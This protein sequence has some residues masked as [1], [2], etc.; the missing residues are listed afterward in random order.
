MR[1]GANAPAMLKNVSSSIIHH[2]DKEGH[3]GEIRYDE[4][5]IQMG[6]GRKLT[7][8]ECLEEEDE[9]VKEFGRIANKISRLIRALDPIYEEIEEDLVGFT[10]R[11]NERVRSIDQLSFNRRL[12]LL[13]TYYTLNSKHDRILRK[14]T[15]HLIAGSEGDH[16]PNNLSLVRRAIDYTCR[17]MRRQS[18]KT[19]HPAALHAIEA[20]RGAAK[21]GLRIVTIIATLLHDVLEERLDEWT[22]AM[23]DRELTDQAYGEYCGRRMKEVPLALRHKIIQKHIDAYN[24]RASGIFFHIGLTL[25]DH[26]R[27]FPVP[28]RHYESLHSIAEMVSALSRRKDQSYYSYLQL[29]LYPK[30]KTELDT[31]EY[32]R[33]RE[34]LIPEHPDADRLLDPYLN[35]VHTFYQ[36]QLGQFSAIEEVRRNAFREILAKILDRMN[37]TRDMDRRHGF[38]V[39][40]RLYGTGFKNIFFLQ[41][42][43][44]K[45]RRPSF[46]TEERRLIELKFINKPKV[47]ALYQ[48]LDDIQYVQERDN[49]EELFA[50]LGKEIERYKPTRAFRRLT[51]PGRGGYFNGL[52]Y[53][54]NDIT[55]GRKSNLVELEK[56]SDKIAEVLVAFRAVLESYL[57]YPTLIREERQSRRL[58]PNDDCGFRPYRIE[59][60]GPGLERRSKAGKDSKADELE[61]KTFSREVI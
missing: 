44:D 35:N 40:S 38:S 26:V 6:E 34:E 2:Y 61:L 18:R 52:I 22:E 31:I 55:M 46:N 15:D 36:T 1:Q 59:G 37:N 53:L 47:A 43:E 39:P 3:G 4:L 14:L 29:L 24:D 50:F 32:D 49:S 57:V 17:M 16:S 21:N 60:M 12:K 11:A 5:L 41:A 42:I 8:A 20:A 23:I 56:R 33:L 19:K 25:Y 28:G 48:I 30:P 9:R 51:P 10:M 7:L 45:F 58:G 27:H 13:N 54:F